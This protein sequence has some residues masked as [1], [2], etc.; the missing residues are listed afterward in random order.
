MNWESIINALA[1]LA[2]VALAWYEVVDGHVDPENNTRQRK[3]LART[4]DP[5]VPGETVEDADLAELD[6]GPTSAP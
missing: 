1:R 5:D 3:R 2:R 4:I 6:R